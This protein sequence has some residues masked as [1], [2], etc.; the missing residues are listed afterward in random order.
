M[1]SAT[2]V[3]VAQEIKSVYPAGAR[4]TTSFLPFRVLPGPDQLKVGAQA[5]WWLPEDLV[6]LPE[7]V[8]NFEPSKKRLGRLNIER[9]TAPCG[10]CAT[11][12]LPPGR[13][14]KF[15]AVTSPS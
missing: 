12:T 15:P 13:Q 10:A 5:D 8:K 11:W 14:T 4:L 9:K 2:D 6:Y 3:K 7:L 1:I